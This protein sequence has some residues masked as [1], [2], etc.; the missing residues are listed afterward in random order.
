ML[1]LLLSALLSAESEAHRSEW[2]RCRATPQAYASD[3]FVFLGEC[4]GRRVLFAADFNR[5][6]DGAR[7]Q[8]EQWFTLHLEKEGWI[9]LK[10]SGEYKLAPSEPLVLRDSPQYTVRGDDAKGWR[11]QGSEAHPTLET[12]ALVSRSQQRNAKGLFTRAG[13][14]AVLKWKQ[15]EFKGQALREVTLLPGLNLITDPDAGLFGDGWNGLYAL[16]GR[17]ESAELLVLHSTG[18]ELESL[19]QPRTGF[20]ARSA[21][22][23]WNDAKLRA[24]RWEQA[25]GF[26]RWPGRWRVEPIRGAGRLEV[27]LSERNTLVSWVVGGACVTV[28]KGQLELDGAKLELYGLAQIVR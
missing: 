17:G 16:A 24:D 2:E 25:A 18:G 22:V 8:N 10:G 23:E 13:G 14:P 6:K 12:G 1:A 26:F 7:L 21:T 20:L 3:F 28:A 9:E 27:A 11:L 5:G 4:D 15:R 19:L